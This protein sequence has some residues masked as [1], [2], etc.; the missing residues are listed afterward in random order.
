MTPNNNN[1]TP[2]PWY[3]DISQQNARK[4]YAY[5][6]VYPLFALSGKLPPFQLRRATRSNTIRSVLLRNRDGTLF[7]DITTPIQNT[8]LHI[9]RFET[10][11]YD[12]IVYPALFPMGLQVPEGVYY[13]EMY[14]GVQ[15]W[16]SDNFTVVNDVSGYL[17][18]VWYDEQNLYYDGGHIDY[19]DLYR[20]FVYLC[21]QLGKPEYTFDEEGETRD[22]FFFPEKQLSAKTFR[23]VFLASEYMCDALRLVRLSDHVIVTSMGN[24]YNCDTFLITPKWQTQGN[25]A[26]VE[27]EFTTDTVVKKIGRLVEP[28]SGDFNNDFNKDFN[29]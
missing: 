7:A 5:G 23:F 17:K 24:E 27:A 14:D 29:N 6:D 15:R 4:S 8:G 11:G 1:L 25:L 16:Y 19:G 10:N 26:S 9:K 18:I 22:G 3:T 13:A 12:L 2:L 28:I 20:N 21:T